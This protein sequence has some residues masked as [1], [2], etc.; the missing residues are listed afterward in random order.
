MKL[1]LPSIFSDH[2][3]LQ[4]GPRVPI[5]G[6]AAAGEAIAVTIAGETRH[7]T[8]HRDGT[9]LLEFDLRTAPAG[10]FELN[11][12]AGESGHALIHDVIVGE[13]WLAS[14]QSNMEWPLELSLG[15]AEEVARA[16]DFSI[17]EF[18]VD[19]TSCAAPQDDVPGRWSVA[20]PESAGKFSAVGFHFAKKL[21]RE[22]NCPVGIVHSSW[23]GSRLEAW[24]APD[25]LNAEERNRA[26]EEH[27]RVAELATARQEYVARYRA[28]EEKYDRKDPGT[29]RP[30]RFAAPG[31]D[32]SSWKSVTLPGKLAEQGLP[33]AGVT[34]L[35]RQVAITPAFAHPGMHLH[36][37]TFREFERLYID[38]QLVRETTCESPQQILNG[39]RNFHLPVTL[40]PGESAWAIRLFSPAGGAEISGGS[41]KIE[42][43]I[44]VDG[45]W[46]A[47]S[48]SEL[49]PLGDE[50]K[51]AFPQPPPSPPG[52]QNIPGALHNGMIAPL[53]PFALAGVLWYQGESNTSLADARLYAG[54]F[55]RLVEDW[56]RRFGRADLPFYYCQLPNFG[57]KTADFLPSNWAVFREVQASSLAL[58]HVGMAVLMNIGD[59]QDI[60]PRNKRDVGER[61]ARLALARD[62]RRSV[63]ANAPEFDRLKIEGRRV[64]LF[65]RHAPCGLIAP[66]LAA[67]HV[68]RYMPDFA[69]AS[70]PLVPPLAG[71]AVHGLA[72]CGEDG[73]WH[74]AHAALED[75]AVIAWSDAVEKP[76]AV[77]YAWADNPT[78]NLSNRAGLPL[79][80]FRTDDFPLE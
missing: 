22:L 71:T 41:F 60:H 43:K 74:W 27:R 70:A 59:A 56:R 5:W 30:E 13:V 39:S 15:G 79:A 29:P 12:A 37:D 25:I 28:W 63:D 50:A 47:T 32:L 33:D 21:A 36:I 2:L 24:L 67:E 16:G 65:F 8:A 66:E 26:Q 42:G 7:A 3:V 44:G 23:G 62:Y 10:P 75:E 20:G 4:R 76:A 17:R 34:W 54:G 11:V 52:L 40:R 64:R 77:R 18:H 46:L 6:R 69:P 73:V 9:W 61:L 51:A 78:C 31:A 55:R 1:I 38:G 68:L 48:E 72:L 35:R 45:P 53:A 14:G 49:P 80:P 58:P 19:Q 57:E